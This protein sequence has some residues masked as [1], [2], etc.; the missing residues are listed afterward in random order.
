VVSLGGTVDGLLESVAISGHVRIKSI[1]VPDPD[2]ATPPVVLLT[3]DFLNVSGRGLKTGSTYS[4]GGNQNDLI[5]PLK[6]S[7]LIQITFPFFTSSAG[8]LS[9]RAGLAS[10]MLMF[11]LSTGKITGGT[12]LVSTP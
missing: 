10:F 1:M 5:R 2:F 6:A 4:T 3:F 8:I 7:D 9:A 11:D 12:V